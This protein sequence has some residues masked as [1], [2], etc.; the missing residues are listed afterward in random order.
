MPALSAPPPTQVGKCADTFI[1]EVG[2]RLSDGVTGAPIEGSGT[3]VSLTNG[4]YLVSYDEIAALKNARV[5]EKVR[6]CLLSIP[7]NCP[8]GDDRG[9][10]YRLFN[11]RTRQTVELPDS[12]HFC[13][14]A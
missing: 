11:Y 5:G 12:Q 4:V 3:S 2:T 1:Q 6:L 10:F 14:G 13:G 9:R 8:P 7:Q